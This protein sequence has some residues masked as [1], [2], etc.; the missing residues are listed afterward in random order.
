MPLTAIVTGSTGFLGRRL[1]AALVEAG[2]RVIGVARRTTLVPGVESVVGDLR[3]PATRAAAWGHGSPDVLFHLAWVTAPGK[4]LASPEN[5]AQLHASVDLLTEAARRCP[6]VIQTGTCLE[7]AAP[8]APVGEDAPLRATHL[9]TACKLAQHALGQR[10]CEVSG[11]RHVWARVFFPVGPGN[12][13]DRLVPRLRATL[14]AGGTFALRSDGSHVRDFV[15]VDDVARAL[16]ACLRDDAPPV[17]N[18]GSGVGTPLREL[19]RRVAGA[20][21]AEDRVTFGPPGAEPDEPP[22][23]VARIDRL[24]ALGWAPRHDALDAA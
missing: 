18:V 16:V 21:H 22:V 20:L 6:R 4:Y 5:T 2:A 12:H 23:L 1:C 15:H 9:Y 3:D 17:V 19:V 11:A 13:P 24:A 14:A 8:A 7:Y 10:L